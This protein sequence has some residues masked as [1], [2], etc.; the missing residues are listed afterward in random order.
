[1][2]TCSKCGFIGHSPLFRERRSICLK[3]YKICRQQYYKDNKIKLDKISK[4]YYF[5]NQEK[6][7]AA[8]KIW[9]KS[10]PDKRK[11]IKNL[12]SKER[13]K[14]NPQ[15]S[16][17]RKMRARFALAIKNNQKS[18]S[19]IYDL[20]CSIST[21][22]AYLNLDCLDKYL[23]PYTGNE[24]LFHIDHIIPLSS[25]DLTNRDQLLKAVNWSNL[26]ILT[27]LEN[28]TKGNK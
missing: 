25:F 1:M 10:N 19:A 15:Y 2:K 23:I 21:L 28:T 22:L 14:N 11:K 3:C 12:Y 16:I 24:S 20:G 9:D 8:S 18:G 4:T 13:Y 27:V 17:E 26:Q 5:Y 7:K 6:A